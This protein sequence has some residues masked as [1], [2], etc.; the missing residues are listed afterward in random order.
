LTGKLSYYS[1]VNV[2]RSSS[3][4]ALGID[5]LTGIIVGI[6]ESDPNVEY[7][8]LVGDEVCMVNSSDVS[9]TGEVMSRDDLYSGSTVNVDPQHYSGDS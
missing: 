8:V 6:S 4:A 7:A 9:F 2:L 3:T 5:G 1:V